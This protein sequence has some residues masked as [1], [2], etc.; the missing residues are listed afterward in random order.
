MD[1]LDFLRKEFQQTVAHQAVGLPATDLHDL[2]GPGNDFFDLAYDL[3]GRF[4]VPV[5]GQVFHSGAIQMVHQLSEG[6]VFV[7]WAEFLVEEKFK[8][9]I[10]VI[11]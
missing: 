3:L 10:E 6:N 2:P 1:H 9:R 11:Q 8:T 7:I 5:F 4:Q